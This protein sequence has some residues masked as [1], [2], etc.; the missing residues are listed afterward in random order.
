M[1]T[2]KGGVSHVK[3]PSEGY[4]AIGGIAAIVSQYRAIP[5]HEEFMP[6]SFFQARIS[7]WRCFRTPGTP[8]MKIL[9]Y[10]VLSLDGIRL[11]KFVSRSDLVLDADRSLD[12]LEP[13]KPKEMLVVCYL[14]ISLYRRAS[15]FVAFQT[16]VAHYCFCLLRINMPFL[17]G[18]L[19]WV[20][21]GRKG[22]KKVVRRGSKKELQ[23]RLLACSGPPRP[24]PKSTKLFVKRKSQ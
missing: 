9:V 18:V 11:S 8:T 22:S 12:F 19:Q 2:N 15:R 17:E 24:A 14:A 4:R 20:L 10:P 13:K 1:Q 5:R 21:E 6:I 23:R 3:L 7:F 16:K